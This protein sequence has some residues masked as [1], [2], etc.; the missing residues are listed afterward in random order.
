LLPTDA[1]TKAFISFNLYRMTTLIS[2]FLYL[3]VTCIC[4]PG[5]SADSL[6]VSSSWV[7]PMWNNSNV[8]LKKIETLL[9][10]FCIM[11]YPNYR[12][13]LVKYRTV[14]IVIVHKIML[15]KLNY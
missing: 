10:L 2:Y 11:E 13:N 1:G 4:Y 9:Y 15:S 5:V 14:I 12:W 8:P 3:A 6:Q 7:F